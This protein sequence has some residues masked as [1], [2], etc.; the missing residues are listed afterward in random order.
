MPNWSRMSSI[1]VKLNQNI[2]SCLPL[3]LEKFA[4]YDF[5][6]TLLLFKNIDQSATNL[7]KMYVIIRSRMSSIMDLMGP[8]M[9]ESS[10]LELEN[11]PYLT[12][13]TL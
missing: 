3:N 10:A 2:Q 6:Y 12:L 1:W 5:V 7:V 4:E 13:F 11:L 8:E 9:S